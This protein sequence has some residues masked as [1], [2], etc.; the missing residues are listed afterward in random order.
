MNI[1]ELT[2]AAKH[3]EEQISFYTEILEL[4]LLSSSE[5][6]AEFSIGDS[7]LKLT[8]TNDFTP[9]HFAFNI[10]SNKEYEALEWLR[11]RVEILPD[12]DEELV[13]LDH[14]NARAIY[15]Y[16][17][18]NNIV[19]FIARKD[20]DNA[21]SEAFSSNL[22]LEISE[23]GAPVDS[24]QSIHD[25]IQAILP[26]PIYDGSMYRFCAM[27]DERGLFVVIDKNI[28]NWFPTNEEAYSSYFKVLLHSEKE[29]KSL[30]FKNG[31]VLQMCT[32][33]L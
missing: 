13:V 29:C 16:D 30:E 27:G 2:I 25:D 22:L 24:I 8:K 7:I 14:W 4:P 18:D 15:F 21:S 5:E 33:D 9:Y 20:L 12:E 31:V 32:T 10:P 23:I 26:I 6:M 19:E 28:K 3:L 17:K 11:E 1:K